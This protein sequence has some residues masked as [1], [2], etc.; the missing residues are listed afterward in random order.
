[1]ACLK[2]LSA[3]SEARSLLH[4]ATSMVLVLVL[5]LVTVEVVMLVVMLGALVDMTAELDL[6]RSSPC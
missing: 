2:V 1:M 3:P 5:V 6:P 4:F